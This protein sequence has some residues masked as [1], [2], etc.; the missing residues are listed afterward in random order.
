M[1]AKLPLQL[2][3]FLLLCPVVA[4]G[5]M[6]V[7]LN[8]NTSSYSFGDGGE[9]R[10]MAGGTPNLVTAIDGSAYSPLTSGMIS[11]QFYFQTFCIEINE[12]FTPGTPYN[13]TISPN[14]MYGSQPPG[15]DPVSVGTA[16]LYSQFAAGTLVGLT[17]GNVPTPYDYIYGAG[18][19]ASAGQLQ[20]AIWWLEREPF[21][22]P[23]TTDPGSGNVFRNAVL[24]QFGGSVL[25]ARA[26]ANGAYGVRALNLGNPGAL[27]DQLV[28]VPQVPEPATA[29]MALLGLGMLLFLRQNPRS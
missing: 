29:S 4:L 26:D 5:Q 27:Q 7:T 25:A 13:V 12:N 17:A 9:F 18:R 10:A 15:G 19:V 2:L 21:V 6:Q 23:D 22:Y 11:G 20:Q 24:N 8:R 1:K 14:A 16:W 3:G 28:I